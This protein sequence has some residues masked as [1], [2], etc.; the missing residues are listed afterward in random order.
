MTLFPCPLC[1]SPD[2]GGGNG[3]CPEC[4]REF[5][6]FRGDR[7]P[8]CGKSFSGVLAM[9]PACLREEARPWRRAWALGDFTGI[10]RKML[11]ALKYRGE[12]HFAGTLGRLASEM[13]ERE[14]LK[15]D[16]IVPVPLHW[17]RRFFRTYNQ[18]ELLAR[19]TGKRLGI[20]VVD[21]LR[22]V[23][24]TGKQAARNRAERLK[25]L[26]NA[27][28]GR[29]GVDLAG[30]RVLL[31]DDVMTTGATLAAAARALEGRDIASLE[32]LTF[33]RGA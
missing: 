21:A 20:P 14:N 24:Y 33:G 29:P 17:I 30:K 1:G 32:V 19:E 7:C 6:F 5:P 13:I 28:A 16:C 25:N 22:R 4:R 23:K 27:F 2:N 15:Y 9:C 26:K 10:N 31:L 8:G 11:L 3:L 18:A 12:A